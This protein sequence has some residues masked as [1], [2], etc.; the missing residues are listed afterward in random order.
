MNDNKTRSC[1]KCKVAKPR[2]STYFT[3]NPRSFDKLDYSCKECHHKY[4][5]DFKNRYPEKWLKHTEYE[6]NRRN[7]NKDEVN[8]RRRQK[9]QSDESYRL[10]R[11]ELKRQYRLKDP[12]HWYA[13][14]TIRGH[15]KSKYILKVTVKEVEEI[16]RNTSSCILCGIP[17][18]WSSL[19]S[20][21]S[22]S[23]DRIDNENTLTKDNIQLLC[24]R[25]N[26]TKGDMKMKQFIEYCNNI[27]ERHLIK[28]EVN[29]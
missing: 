7:K 18:N 13:L 29:M 5:Q 9:Y 4:Y 23:L 26:M 20:K 3:S 10:S 28:Q 25:C 17:I 15:K 21:D 16:C 19:K 12:I 1:S 14:E 8:Q 6:K 22:P 24:L 2:T 27:A 11:K